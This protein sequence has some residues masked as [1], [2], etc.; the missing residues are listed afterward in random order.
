MT[1]SS[2]SVQSSLETRSEC[3]SSEF[4]PDDGRR[5]IV[6]SKTKH[7]GHPHDL[8]F[9]SAVSHTRKMKPGL[10][11]GQSLVG[12]VIWGDGS[13]ATATYSG[14][15][16]CGEV[17]VTPSRSGNTKTRP[18][19]DIS[20]DNFFSVGSKTSS[21]EP[22]TTTNSFYTTID[23]STSSSDVRPT[24]TLIITDE[25]ASGGSN[26][27]TIPSTLLY[28]HPESNSYLSDSHDR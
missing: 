13:P 23:S 10:G 20:D 2:N 16:L 3:S 21:S 12:G 27:Q 6:N 8:K 11:L 1:Q 26:T 4:A 18:L 28:W 14:P 15:R 7:E 22:C 9:A 24:T 17:R 25:T 5:T 19:S